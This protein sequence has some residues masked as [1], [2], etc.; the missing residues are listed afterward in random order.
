[1]KKAPILLT[2]IMAVFGTAAITN[3]IK[4]NKVD[5]T[6]SGTSP[7][8]YTFNGEEGI[9]TS[10]GSFTANNVTWNATAAKAIGYTSSGLSIGSG[11]VGQT[12]YWRMTTDVS[13][14]GE[15]I[16]ISKITI[17]SSTA[18][19]RYYIGLGVDDSTL[20]V[21]RTSTDNQTYYLAFNTPR[22][23]GTLKIGVKRADTQNRAIYIKSIEI[24]FVPIVTK[25]I[26]MG[27]TLEHDVQIN[28]DV[29]SKIKY[30]YSN[31][32]VRN[33]T[34]IPGRVL[35]ISLDSYSDTD[36]IYYG[37][38]YDSLNELSISNNRTHITNETYY[39]CVS[40]SNVTSVTYTYYE[41][42]EHLMLNY[43]DYY[44]HMNDYKSSLGL[45][46]TYLND[47]IDSYNNLSTEQKGY[48]ESNTAAYERLQ[49]W[50]RARGYTIDNNEIKPSSKSFTIL[51]TNSGYYSL[52]ILMITGVLSIGLLFSVIKKRNA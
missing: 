6:Y 35:S 18:G 45:C 12:S 5:A 22:D 25:T 17:R 36:H 40:S 51:S 30:E 11:T 28:E 15:N 39:I 14:F 44:L 52:I 23:F 34:A 21:Q 8:S 47:M 49:A 24:E 1:M 20:E 16:A 13:Q 3:N 43:A 19:G 48:L 27:E 46:G 38:T 26:T 10:G 42:D 33:Y 4:D 7:Y 29:Y 2:L 50:L 41:D 31:N 37:N 9:T 32:S